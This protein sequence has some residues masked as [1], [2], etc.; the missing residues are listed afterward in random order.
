MFGKAVFENLSVVCNADFK[1]HVDK[2]VLSTL[3][4]SKRCNGNVACV[5]L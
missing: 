2:C 3:F 5:K 1:K 4:Y